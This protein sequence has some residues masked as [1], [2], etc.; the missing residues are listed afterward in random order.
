MV[1]L[2][3]ENQSEQAELTLEFSQE[4]SPRLPSEGKI[5]KVFSSQ[6]NHQYNYQSIY[7]Y[8]ETKEKI[9]LLRTPPTR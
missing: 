7:H 1:I 5:K 6:S 3:G 8:S 9:I 2:P 4:A